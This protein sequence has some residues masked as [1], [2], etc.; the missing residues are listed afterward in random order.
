MCKISNIQEMVNRAGFF[1][2]LEGSFSFQCQRYLLDHQSNDSV[3]ITLHI[4]YILRSPIEK[5]LTINSIPFNVCESYKY[6]TMKYYITWLLKTC[7]ILYQ[8]ITSYFVSEG[9]KVII[10]SHLLFSWISHLEKKKIKTHL[11]DISVI[12]K[13]CEK[14]ILW[15]SYENI[16]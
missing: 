3:I 1:Y 4:F 6:H 16:N 5:T 14:P 11:S 7:F 13:S 9:R 15:C 12:K 8:S 2:L 10:F